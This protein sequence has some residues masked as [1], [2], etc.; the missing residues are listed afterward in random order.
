M[1]TFVTMAIALLT[2]G[3]AFAQKA[4]TDADKAGVYTSAAE[5]ADAVSKLPKQPLASVPVYKMGPFNVNVEHRLGTPAAAQAASVH[6]KDAELFYMIDGTATLVTGG[7]LVEGAKDG[8][9]W[10]GKGIEGGKSQKMSKGD[11]MMVPAGVP[12][13]FT[14][15]EGQ[16]TEFSLHLPVK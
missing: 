12:H 16:I 15:I 10:R 11:F 9:N 14:N 6:D 13:W 4:I 5:V 3:T 1:K 2:V 8:D 7:K